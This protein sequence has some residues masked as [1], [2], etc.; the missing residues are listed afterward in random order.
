MAVE[1]FEAYKDRFLCPVVLCNS[2]MLHL[3]RAFARQGKKA[4]LTNPSDCIFLLGGVMGAWWQEGRAEMYAG[5]EHLA[6]HTTGLFHS[7]GCSRGLRVWCFDSTHLVTPA[8]IARAKRNL[9]V[10]NIEEDPTPL[11]T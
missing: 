7:L 5:E 4:S 8:N 1:L 2:D 6:I 9:R 3:C 11:L 10:A